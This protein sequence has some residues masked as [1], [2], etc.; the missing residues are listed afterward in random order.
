[1][2]SLTER[3][4]QLIRNNTDRHIQDLRVEIAPGRVLLFGSTKRYFH[5]QIAQESARTLCPGLVVDNHI[6]VQMGQMKKMPHFSM[7]KV[8]GNLVG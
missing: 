2:G 3:I 1:M 5:K 6:C 8:E 4:M 7:A